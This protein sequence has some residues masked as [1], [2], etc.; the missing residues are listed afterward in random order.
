VRLSNF[1]ESTK[2][3]STFVNALAAFHSSSQ[4]RNLPVRLDPFPPLGSDNHSTEPR[5]L[6]RNSLES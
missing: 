4:H 2:H 1:G 6:A 3:V 5:G